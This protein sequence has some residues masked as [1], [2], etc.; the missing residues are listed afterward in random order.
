MKG[1]NYQQ[2][3]S[4]RIEQEL[5]KL[6]DWQQKDN[7]LRARFKFNDFKAAFAFM[8]QVALAA[9]KL[10]HHPDWSNSYSLVTIEL[11]SHQAN[12]ITNFD[13]QLATQISQLYDHYRDA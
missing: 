7:K 12:A 3:D 5:K 4:K 10:D 6:P 1:R 9:E 11:Y 2:L 13:L 8:T